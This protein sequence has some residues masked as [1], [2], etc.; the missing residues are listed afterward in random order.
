MTI[1][2]KV[3]RSETIDSVISLADVKRALNI[4][5]TYEDDEVQSLI[6]VAFGM[7]EKYCH[8]LFTPCT[9]VAE[10]TDGVKKFFIPYGHNVSISRV[11]VDGTET[12]DYSF[13][14]VSEKF[15]LET[16]GN[17]KT[18][19]IEY[20]CGFTELPHAIDRGVKYLVSTLRSSGQDFTVGMDV[21]EMPLRAVHILDAEKHHAI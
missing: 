2:T 3:T 19:I 14:E 7:A 5:D 4:L 21:S 15:T 8:R 12:S 1:Y 17:Y 16:T 18:L 20:T 13:S 6:Y 10:R 11:L 9:V